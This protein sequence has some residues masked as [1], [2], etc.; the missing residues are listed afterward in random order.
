LRA[1][2]AAAREAPHAGA[3]LTAADRFALSLTHGLAHAGVHSIFF[4]VSWLPLCLGDGTIYAAT[5]PQLSYYLVAAL[6][7]LGLAGVL[8]GGMV[9]CF[10]GLERKDYTQGVAP[11]L[12]H[13]A[14]ACETLAN[15]SQGGCV[16]SVPLLLAAGAATAAW[17]VRL[18]WRRTGEALQPRAA[19]AAAHASRPAP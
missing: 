8:T 14:A 19:P 10:E 4:F 6:S 13:L 16:A 9:I 18:W 5:C 1:L 15:F 17:A 12:V 3:A 2:E 11:S 7:T